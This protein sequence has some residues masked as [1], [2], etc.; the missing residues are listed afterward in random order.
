MYCLPRFY[1]SKIS[2]D[3]HLYNAYK[4]NS[5]DIK[6]HLLRDC[7][8]LHVLSCTTL[9]NTLIN[10]PSKMNV[11]IALQNKNGISSLTIIEEKKTTNNA[12]W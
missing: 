3:L 8:Y 10:H 1:I 6:W 12:L 2:R 7:L 9:A 11:Y 5:F 4:G